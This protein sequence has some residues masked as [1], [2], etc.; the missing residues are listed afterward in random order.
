M[1]AEH[2]YPA[3]PQSVPADLARSTKSYRLHAWLAMAGLA[4]FVA[5]YLGLAS[6]FSWTAYRLVVAETREGET[7]W[8]LI[9]AVS[10]AFLAIFLWKALFFVKHRQEIDDIEVTAAEQPKLF[11]F[12]NRL[13][14]EAGAP[15]AHRVFLSPRVNA[16]VFYEL[17]V[18]NLLFPTRK[19]LEIGLGLVN[20]LSLGEFK[21]VLAHEF[22]HFAQRSMAVGRWVY[23]AQQIA[24]HIIGKRDALDA[25]LRGLSRFDV[26][27]AWM[28][29]LLSLVVW[30]IRSM[31]ET[32][33]RVVLLAQRA[34]SREMELQA[35]LV[36]VSLT[37][38]DALVHAL[39]KLHVADDAWGRTLAFAGK[40][41]REK[42]TVRDLF[43][44]QQHVTSKLRQVFDDPSY[45]EIEPLPQDRPEQHRVFKTSIAQPPRMWSTHPENSER[46]QNAKHRYIAATIDERSAW[47]LFDAAQSLKEQ[48]SAHV[49][50]SIEDAQS[51][52]PE[53]SI[54][55]LDEQF[56][57]PYFDKSYRG[58]YLGRALTDHFPTAS[59]LYGP[60]LRKDL[61]VPELDAIYPESLARDLERLRSLE[62]ER[63]TLQ[64]L[65]EGFLTAPGGVIHHRGKRL[66]R[67]DLQDALDD[68]QEE[69]DRAR[70]VVQAHDRR[71]RSVHLSAAKQLGGGWD[72]YLEGLLAILHYAEHAEANLHDAHG[73]LSNVVTTVAMGGRS[74]GSLLDACAEVHNALRHVHE[75]EGLSIVLDRTLLRRLKIESWQASLGPLQLP[76]ATEGNVGEWLKVI[77]SWV[78]TAASKL[79]ELRQAALEQLLLAEAQVARF[80]RN[81]MQPGAAPA[82]TTLP[83]QYPVLVPGGERPRKQKLDLW[84]RFHIADG[85]WA[86]LAR[87]T[88][89]C[90]IIAAVLSV[91]NTVGST[92]V[93]VYNGLGRAVTVSIGNES[94]H[95]EPFSHAQLMPGDRKSYVV[96]ATVAGDRP[97]EQFE[98]E[99][100]AGSHRSIYNVGGAS[101]LVEWT[102]TYGKGFEANDRVLGPVRWTS[103]DANF[104]FEDPPE[105]ISSKSGGGTRTAVSAVGHDNP[106]ALLTLVPSEAEREKV[107]AMHARWDASD[108]RYAAYWLAAASRS[109]AFAEILQ[110]RLALQPNDVLTLRA[111]QDYTDP[112]LHAE[113]CNRHRSAAGAQRDNVDLQY[114]AARCIEDE[115]QRDQEF[116]ALYAKAPEHG[117]LALAVAYTYLQHS[118]WSDAIAPLDV[119]RRHVASMQERLAV[120]TLRVRRMLSTDGDAQTTDLVA[121]SDALRYYLAIQSGAG[122]QPGNDMAYYHLNRGNLDEAAR[123]F[124]QARQGDPRILRLIAASDG[125]PRDSI[126]AAMALPIAEGLDPESI[127]TSLA[128]AL[129]E[130]KDSEPYLSV[131]R[132]YKMDGQQQQIVDFITTVRRSGN[133]ADAERLLDGVD[134]VGRGHAYSAALVLMGEE[135]PVEW[136]RAVNRL[137]FVPERPYFVKAPRADTTQ[138]VEDKPGVKRTPPRL[139]Y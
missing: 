52:S 111:E 78:W 83:A 125:A 18:I 132:S 80:A 87:L 64:G 26:R 112:Q 73:A 135:A 21:A 138:T 17:S 2:V 60:P 27:V 127:W 8:S 33:F 95:L 65:K 5:L 121:G 3:G 43:A 74:S 109:P 93:N 41:A 67:Q 47:V 61:I 30:S 79:S 14:D 44:I 51:P 39:R 31:M 102:A 7:F 45:G 66:R 70:S 34:L 50:R 6:W 104:V 96:K 59:A 123:E 55:K 77:D 11:A 13:A 106:S 75:D 100:P 117:W 81:N 91:G 32:V 29:W 136:R 103:T 58:S 76:L 54:A 42:R 71:C 116:S 68:L 82:A 110:A 118:R 40:E 53:E 56:N 98:V 126:R 131:L 128:L 24:G 120:D 101:A 9:A 105:Q 35:D 49:F 107:I 108:T 57:R 115:A 88:V 94:L 25:F 134:A 72:A 20:F 99:I 85:W 62:E 12:I 133:S 46:E 129:R 36:A 4:L 16:S 28:G 130:G 97:I 10:S 122:L 139:I 92:L 86:T 15:R 113:V 19:N 89:A 23:I 38:S 90:G 1:T 119:A 37:G 114:L 84:D 22:G 69:L 124:A 137:L 63:Q 48:M